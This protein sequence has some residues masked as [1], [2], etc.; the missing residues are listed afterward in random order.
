MPE[1]IWGPFALI[2][3]VIADVMTATRS[4]DR[5]PTLSEF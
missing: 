4:S 5:R 2:I 1:M 3:M